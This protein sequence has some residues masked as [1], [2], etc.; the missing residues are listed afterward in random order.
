VHQAVICAATRRDRRK[1]TAVDL[2][3]VTKQAV[4]ELVARRPIVS[5]RTRLSCVKAFMADEEH[6]FADVPSLLKRRRDFFNASRPWAD[7]FEPEWI[8]VSG[9]EALPQARLDLNVLAQIPL[10]IRC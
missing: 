6:W 7:E 8:R 9:I 3:K 5:R 2:V 1:P 10:A 4:S